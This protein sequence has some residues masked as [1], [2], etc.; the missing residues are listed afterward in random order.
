MKTNIMRSALVALLPLALLATNTLRA[1][2]KPVATQ[3][4]TADKA[5]ADQQV[6]RQLAAYSGGQLIVPPLTVPDSLLSPTREEGVM[7]LRGT[8]FQIDALRS[9]VFIDAAT[10]KPIFSK[11][12]PMESAVNLLMNVLS[13]NRYSIRVTQHQYGNVKK[14]ITM[15]MKGVYQVLATDRQVFCNVTKIDKGSIEADLVMFHKKLNNIHLF[16]IH[17]DM[18]ELFKAEGKLTAQLYANIPQGS[19]KS[20]FSKKDKEKKR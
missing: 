4:V 8:S 9:D 2:T 17:M 14:T 6:F 11:R 16:T 12:Y 10:R 7:L 1:Q 15:P 18:D 3:T 20:I 13:D 19:I 5:E